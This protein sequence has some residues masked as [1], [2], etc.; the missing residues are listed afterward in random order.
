MRTKI[1]AALACGALMGTF[2][3]GTASHTLAQA[4][5]TQASTHA[6]VAYSYFEHGIEQGESGIFTS[7]ES[8]PFGEEYFHFVGQ[9]QQNIH[10]YSASYY[11]D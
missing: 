4:S 11:G 5:A 7:R 10:T 2:L 9:G 1:V 6:A 8:D 3:L